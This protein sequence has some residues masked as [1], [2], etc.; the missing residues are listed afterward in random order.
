MI[1]DADTHI[2]PYREAPNTMGFEELLRRMDRAAVDKALTWLQPLY[3]PGVEAAN[4]Y[5]YQ[6]TK[7]H[8]DRILGFG[9]ADPNLGVERA[10]DAVKRCSD[11]YGFY[12]V[13]LNGAQNSF[14][15]DD[16]VLSIPV[17]EEIARRG[18]LLALHVG[19]DDYERTHPFR[20]GKIARRFPQ[21]QILVVHMGGVA[22]ADLTQAAIE[23]AEEHPNLTLI[24]S[25]VRSLPI[26]KAIKTLGSC[27]VCFGSDSPFELMHVAVARY[28]ALLEGEVSGED[29][30]NV[31][32]GNMIRLLDLRVPGP[33]LSRSSAL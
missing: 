1:I 11:D 31:M 27:R 28:K 29:E 20:V 24:G 10:K 16:P 25:A 30:Y 18:K 13:K 12:G 5:V 21:L 17:I 33:Q 14:F 7:Q 23:I 22:F 19:A 32:A 15:V 3:A 4:E 8:P 6:A 2:S 9:W 26:L